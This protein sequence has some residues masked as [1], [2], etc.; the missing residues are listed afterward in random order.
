MQVKEY[1]NIKDD[2]VTNYMVKS[3]APKIFSFCGINIY[4]KDSLAFLTH[5]QWLDAIDLINTSKNDLDLMNLITIFHW[6]EIDKRQ[7]KKYTAEAKIDELLKM[8]VL[9]AYSVT[10]KY[11]DMITKQAAKENE[12]LQTSM[13]GKER[14]AYERANYDKLNMFGDFGVRCNIAEMLGCFPEDVLKRKHNE[15]YYYLLYKM[16]K[17]E[18]DKIYNEE[19]NKV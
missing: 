15:I 2:D 14:T 10:F 8:N 18:C 12:S 5:H 11:A 1:F 4:T 6:K 3:E 13:T 19:I 17:G 16:K 7:Y 9:H